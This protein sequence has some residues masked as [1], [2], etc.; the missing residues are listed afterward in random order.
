MQSGR[1]LALAVLAIG[2]NLGA[3]LAPAEAPPGPPAPTVRLA[4]VR[5][6]DSSLFFGYTV[7]VHWDGGYVD[8]VEFMDVEPGSLAEKA[9]LRAGDMLLAVD[10]KRVLGITQPAF[11]ALMTREFDADGKVIFR[12]TIG[13]G[14]F[15]RRREIVFR[16]KGFDK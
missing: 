6:A 11:E 5:V 1:L 4:P 9:G 14:F 3:G 2:L 13:R 7:D 15:M 16:V 10:G 8:T 12:F